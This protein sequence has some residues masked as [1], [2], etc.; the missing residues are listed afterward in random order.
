[1]NPCTINIT[2]AET[3]EK[4]IYM[5]YKLSDFYQNH[6]RYVKSRHDAQLR[7]VSTQTPDLLEA[8]CTSYYRHNESHAGDA[9][10]SISN[11][12]SPCGLIAW[13]VFNDSFSLV[14][15]DGTKVAML[16]TG[17]AW[18]SDV[19]DKFHNAGDSS[20]GTNFPPFAHWKQA[21]CSG[22]VDG[23]T[24]DASKLADC[25][26]ANPDATTG[27]SAGWCFFGS[28]YC[29]EDE[30]FMV[31]MRTAGLPTFRKLYAIIDEDLAPGDY[32]IVVSNGVEKEHE[33]EA[34][35][36]NY[37]HDKAQTQLFP[38]HGFDGEKH[39]VLSTV[40]WMGGKN[41]FL[42]YAYVVVGAIC[43]TLALL[44]LI[45]D[46]LSPR[47]LGDPSYITFNKKEGDK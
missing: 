27:L 11:V 17:V 8:D 2:I 37:Y 14:K 22:T 15:E 31:W 21:S 29:N 20:T 35:L 28:G 4:P 19:S 5:Y 43:L 44:F 13:S 41:P 9:Y 26:A 42:G 30:H 46:R 7:G 33:G 34:K 32:S 10:N 25:E 24:L 36:W 16:E 40:S 23:V 39:I 3:M 18:P 12:I 1:M 47:R 38:V 45:K 6:R